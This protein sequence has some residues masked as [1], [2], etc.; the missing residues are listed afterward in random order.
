M[1]RIGFKWFF[2]IIVV[3]VTIITSTLP[4]LPM[5]GTTV[6]Y[7]KHVKIAYGCVMCLLN[8]TYPGIYSIV[9]AGVADAF[10]PEHYQANFELLFS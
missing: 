7:I 1:F 6:V 10:G 2:M 3:I 4:I 8:V 5:I 9:A